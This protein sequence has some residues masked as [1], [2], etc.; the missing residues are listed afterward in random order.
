MSC[1]R[2]SL[3]NYPVGSW[4]KYLRALRVILSTIWSPETSALVQPI[5]PAVKILPE[6][7]VVWI[8][9]PTRQARLF[10]DDLAFAQASAAAEIEVWPNLWVKLDSKAPFGVS[11]I[12]SSSTAITRLA[13]PKK[14]PF[15]SPVPL[16]NGFAEFLTIMPRRS[17]CKLPRFIDFGTPS[18]TKA[19]NV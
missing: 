18:L 16:N 6:P 11:G 17:R 13:A 19:R 12:P 8:S 3:S 10:P 1:S 2:T 9:C 5:G 15:L 14:S 7:N 4:P